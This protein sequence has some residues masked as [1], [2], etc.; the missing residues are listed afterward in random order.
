MP[1]MCVRGSWPIVFT[2]LLLLLVSAVQSANNTAPYPANNTAP[3]PAKGTAPSC[4]AKLKSTLKITEIPNPHRVRRDDR[5]LGENSGHI[6]PRC[7]VKTNSTIKITVVPDPHRVRR[8]EVPPREN[9]GKIAPRCKANFNSTV[10]AGNTTNATA[11]KVGR[12]RRADKPL[13]SGS[14]RGSPGHTS[15]GSGG[16]ESA[17]GGASV[18][19]GSSGNSP[20]KAIDLA[21]YI[22]QGALAAAYMRFSDEEIEADLVKKG[23]LKSGG[24]DCKPVHGSQRLQEQ[25]LGG[26]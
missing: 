24:T 6:A 10:S 11:I 15:E 5:P 7:S 19:S 16:G 25:W 1:S 22:S 12:I 21:P 17:L 26:R 4:N 2:I 20:L 8:D 9:G 14:G 3:H 23:K 13:S 18:G